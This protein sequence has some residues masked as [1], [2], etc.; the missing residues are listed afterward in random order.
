MR[1]PNHLR[2][3]CTL[4]LSAAALALLLGAAPLHTA[5]AQSTT[6]GDIRRSSSSPVTPCLVEAFS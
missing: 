2:R 4:P 5:S 3:A 1:T 6:D